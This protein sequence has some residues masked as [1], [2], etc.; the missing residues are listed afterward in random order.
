MHRKPLREVYLA[1]KKKKNGGRHVI[2]SKSGSRCAA[3]R[4][5]GWFCSNNSNSCGS[6]LE[7]TA[8]SEDRNRGPG[9]A[10]S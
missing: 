4:G 8:A 6:E 2:S 1:T 3:V 7:V 5:L 10:E 9:L